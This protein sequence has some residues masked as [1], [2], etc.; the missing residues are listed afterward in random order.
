MRDLGQGDLIV[1]RH[2]WDTWSDPALP[3]CG[4]Q[5]GIDYERLLQVR[6]THI[7]LQMADTPPQLVERG[8]EHGFVVKNFTILSLEEI[9]LATRE[10]WHW[11]GQP[12][13][14]DSEVAGRAPIEDRMDK[15]WSRHESVDAAKIGRV[16]LLS[17]VDPAGS[18]GPG[19]WHHDIL[20]RIGA[21]PAVTTGNVFVTMDAE[22]VLQ[23]APDAI[24]L[25]SPRLPNTPPRPTPYTPEEL[26][27]SMGKLAT[28]HIPAMKNGRIAII[29]H[30]M[31]HLPST[32][33]IEVAEEMARVLE[34]WSK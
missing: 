31:S 2:N 13:P 15:A 20:T 8:R 23:A 4:D 17:N 28:L 3:V 12:G 27:R 26:L 11:N 34:A 1:G 5:D 9:R 6:P 10:L 22:D 21:T 32:A 16:M 19:S 33:M 14:L 24:I 30:P 29:D 7:F 18:L 25:F